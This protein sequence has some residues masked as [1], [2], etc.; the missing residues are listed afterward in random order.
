MTWAYVASRQPVGGEALPEQGLQ[1]LA[2]HLNRVVL[3][4][5]F[6]NERGETRDI[7]FTW[8]M[9]R[10]AEDLEMAPKDYAAGLL[11]FADKAVA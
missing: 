2:C 4:L 3:V 10:R 9:Q 1:P 11:R 7:E 6:E 8:A 5:V